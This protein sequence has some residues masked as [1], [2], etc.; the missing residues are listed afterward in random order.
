MK[1]ERTV[2]QSGS[3]ANPM[4]SGNGK[5]QTPGTS[6][7][8]DQIMETAKTA[9]EKIVDL[10]GATFSTVNKRGSALAKQYPV[11]VAAGALAVGFLLGAAL[12]RR[13]A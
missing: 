6:E 9:Y 8:Q 7:I 10:T 2:T 13:R 3:V 1:E 11:E 5:W 12:F 4:K